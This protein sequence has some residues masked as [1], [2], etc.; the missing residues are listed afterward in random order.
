MN[1][2]YTGRTAKDEKRPAKEKRT[3]E[4]RPAKEKIDAAHVGSENSHQKNVISRDKKS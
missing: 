1:L 4:T 3:S 2:C